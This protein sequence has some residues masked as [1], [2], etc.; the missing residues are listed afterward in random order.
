M[1]K[2]A[3]RVIDYCINHDIRTLVVGYN[4]TFQKDSNIVKFLR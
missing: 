1:N 3:R 4:E 2:T